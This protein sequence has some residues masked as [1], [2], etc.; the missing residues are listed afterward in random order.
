MASEERGEQ[1]IIDYEDS[2]YRTDFWLG[3]GRE[4]EDAVER[5][6]IGAMLPNAGARVVDIGAGFG[7]LA[8]LYA[9][10][11]EVVLVDYS[12]SQLEYARQ[13]LGDER[14]VYIA[15]DLYRM[16]L[17]TGAVDAAVMVRVLHHIADVPAA[18]A[19]LARILVPQG[20][21]V[22]EFANKR[23]LK[24]LARYLL[25]RGVNPFLPEPH[26]FTELHFD[27][28]PAWVR[29]RLAEAGFHVEHL[30]AVSLFRAGVLKRHVPLRALV[31]ADS[32]LQ[33]VTAP[34]T[35]GPSVFVQAQRQGKVAKPPVDRA[36]LFR[37]PDCG[38]EPLESVE[39]GVT[40][41]SCGGFWPVV[42][43]VYR[44]K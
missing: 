41:H 14:F 7:R 27:F 4:Y 34:L 37:C 29:E 21:L 36:A 30:R 3:Q 1:R 8:D 2:T 19:Q 10:Y 40:C 16:P 33:R 24:N 44:F 20:T 11:R 38:Q 22:L 32:A 25:R 43:G 31:A 26:E 17:A 39:G 13:Q 18:M 12:V 9:G 23:H 35:P 28:H 42:N 5:V 6:A 15:A